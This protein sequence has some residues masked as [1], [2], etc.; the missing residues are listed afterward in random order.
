MRQIPLAIGLGNEP[1]FDNF[2]VGDNGLALHALQA[3]QLPSPP[4]YLHGPAGAGKSHLLAALS[5][6]VRQAGGR[7]AWFDA[8]AP[9]PWTFDEG[10]SLVVIDGADRLDAAHQHAAFT[11]FVEAATHGVQMASAGRL[12]PVALPVREDLRTRFGWGPSYPLVPLD[13]A[14]TRAALRREAVDVESTYANYRRFET[15]TRIK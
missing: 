15:T 3:L 7:C 5:A 10:W 12:P 9:L 11:L 8:D 2:V 6:A 1:G 14:G 13:E 4:V